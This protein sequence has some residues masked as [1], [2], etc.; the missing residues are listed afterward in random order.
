VKLEQLLNNSSVAQENIA[1]SSTYDNWLKYFV[2]IQFEKILV[3]RELEQY[4]VDFYFP[5]S[6]SYDEG[7]S[8]D[9]ELEANKYFS[10]QVEQIKALIC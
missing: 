6:D 2:V 10:K 5:L 1:N 8:F 4:I 7:I 9:S 3:L